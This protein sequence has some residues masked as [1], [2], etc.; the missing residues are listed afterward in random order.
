LWTI[1]PSVDERVNRL[2][3]EPV[4]DTVDWNLPH[5]IGAPRWPAELATGGWAHQMTLDQNPWIS[6]DATHLRTYVALLPSGG[7]HGGAWVV[8][9]LID[10]AQ[11]EAH[12][13][14]DGQEVVGTG[15]FPL[16]FDLTDHPEPAAYR[17]ELNLRAPIGTEGPRQL[18]SSWA[19]TSGQPDGN[20]TSP[21]ISCWGQTS[22]P[23]VEQTCRVESLLMLGYELGP[24]LDLR[25]RAERAGR[26]SFTVDGY[27]ETGAADPPMRQLDVEVSYDGGDHW[28]P[29]RAEP[30]G[31]SA[32]QVSFTPLRSVAPGSWVSLRVH[33]RDAAGSQVS[34]TLV[35]LFQLKR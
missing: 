18:R 27:H 32:F 29:A 31:G 1:A 5:T 8:S 2:V 6:R 23:L 16:Y 14:R 21:G 34:Q 26:I 15:G 28:T 17:Y 4:T 35:D 19:F 11:G 3:S 13:Y 12:L 30:D 33:A 25:N 10:P 20:E 9:P 24:V 22:V 7:D